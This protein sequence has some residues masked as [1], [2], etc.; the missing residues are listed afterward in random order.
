MDVETGKILYADTDITIPENTFSYGIG[1]QVTCLKAS[2][3][4]F[5]TIDDN[6][7]GLTDDE[8]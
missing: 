6:P 3:L 2:Q 7:V 4:L 8:P 1:R 5:N